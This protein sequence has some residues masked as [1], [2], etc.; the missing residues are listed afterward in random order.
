MKMYVMDVGGLKKHFVKGSVL[1]IYYSVMRGTR[2]RSDHRQTV[3][4]AGHV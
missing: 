4:P 3:G 1:V 2:R